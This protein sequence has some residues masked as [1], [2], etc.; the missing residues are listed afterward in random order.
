MSD[1]NY[2]GKAKSFELQDIPSKAFD[3][4]CK[5]IDSEES[6]DFDDYVNFSVLSFL[7]QDYGYS[8]SNEISK[9][10]VDLAWSYMKK[11]LELCEDKYGKSSVINF[12]KKY[13][14]MILLGEL[15]SEDDFLGFIKSGVQDAAFCMPSSPE[16]VEEKQATELD[17]S[18]P[19]TFKERYILSM[20]S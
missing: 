14:D 3:Y 4:Y 15:I 11:S 16:T 10:Q 9:E 5:A 6:L 2:L 8:S 7:F 13:Y 1:T 17:S 18:I 19:K 12:W 20:S